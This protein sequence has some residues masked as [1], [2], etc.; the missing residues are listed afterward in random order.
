[1]TPTRLS[2]LFLVPFI[3]CLAGAGCSSNTAGSGCGGNASCEA[4]EVCV[5]DACV[6]LCDSDVQCEPGLVCE[7]SLC[8]SGERE[9]PQINALDGD[10]SLV[11]PDA[12]GTHCM[13]GGFIVDGNNLLGALF[14]LEPRPGGTPIDLMVR[15]G[16]SAN[17]VRLVLADVAPGQYTLHAVNQAGSDQTDLTLLQGPPG[18]DLTANQLV[19]HIN[20]ATRY[21]GFG[22]LPVGAGP[23][24]VAAGDHDH[25][26]G[27]DTDDITS[28]TLSAGR[29][30][31]GTGSSDVAAGDHGHGP[32]ISCDVT[33]NCS[34]VCIGSDC[35]S[36]WP[37]NDARQYVHWGA[38]GCASGYTK[39]YDG[40]MY[41]SGAGAHHANDTVCSTGTRRWV[42]RHY[43]SN[44]AWEQAQACSVCAATAARGC[45]TKWGDNSCASGYS[46]MFD[47]FMYMGGQND[48]YGGTIVCSE[49]AQATNYE[50]TSSGASSWQ[51]AR[52]CA[53]CCKN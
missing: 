52:Q 9:Q 40:W 50:R 8:V 13:A 45:Y 53:T 10:D 20:T 5:S 42:Y 1:M 37:V 51:A 24:Q 11:C 12:N 30:P 25:V 22:I 43:I 16:G 29:L 19:D 27:H 48:G 49:T 6:P 17:Q 36:S 2:P 46:Q 44:Y 38:T 7:D 14:T 31:V 23:T 33:G 21:L 3:A 4:G 26:H 35:R 32:D 47:G 41:Y 15:A 18:P 39:L 34:Q 28:G